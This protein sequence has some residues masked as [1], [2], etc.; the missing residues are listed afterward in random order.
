MI[1]NFKADIYKIRKE[2]V[3][4]ISIFLCVLLEFLFTFV[5]REK[6]G[7]TGVIITLSSSTV[8]LPLFF[9]AVDLFVWGED[10]VSRTINTQIIKASSR[11]SL[12]VYK[13]VTTV[14][15]ST[16]HL[17]VAYLSV[18][19]FRGIFADSVSLSAVWNMAVYQYPYY[20]CI[21][22]LSIFIFNY[23]D[24]VS[25]AQLIYIVIV[26]LF[27]N[28]M[29]FVMD[30]VIDPE[31]LNHFLLFNQLKG[32]TGSGNFLTPSVMIALIFSVLYFIFSY[33]LF[34]EREFK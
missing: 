33:Y 19:V 11:L 24:K 5:M 10:F 27:D 3:F 14:L 1:S 8:F 28:L 7:D 34:S 21:M 30:N 15:Y 6:S 25:Y 18:A 16:A 20:L 2:R 17:F 9:I 23:V 22:F 4:S 26:I 31:L 12:F 32:I 13:V 29:S